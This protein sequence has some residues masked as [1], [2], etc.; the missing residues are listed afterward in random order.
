[1]SEDDVLREME[2]QEVLFSAEDKTNLRALA[3]EI[4][5]LFSSNDVGVDD[6]IAAMMMLTHAHIATLPEEVVAD[7]VAQC[8]AVMTGNY[9]FEGGLH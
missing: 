6:G 3:G 4:A 1:M 5:S 8:V 2:I 9:S 7:V